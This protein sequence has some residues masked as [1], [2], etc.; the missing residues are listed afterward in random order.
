MNDRRYTSA[1]S[2]IVAVI[3]LSCTMCNDDDDAVPAGDSG[4]EAGAG[5]GPL[6]RGS[7]RRRR[8]GGRR[9]D[10]DRRWRYGRRVR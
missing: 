6:T 2:A 3:G 4:G 10:R 5:G 1:L 7:R 8:G 9:A